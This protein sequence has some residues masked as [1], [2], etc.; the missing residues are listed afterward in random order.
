MPPAPA[1]LDE[2]IEAGWKTLESRSGWKVRYL[3]LGRGTRTWIAFHGFG[4]S[5]LDLVQWAEPLLAGGCRVFLIELP[6]HGK[7]SGPDDDEALT[8]EEWAGLFGQLCR[9]EQIHTLRL[10]GFS[11]GAR[12]A[13]QTAWQ[14]KGTV[15]QLVLCAPDGITNSLWFTLGTRT[16]LG[17]QI[18]A[19]FT[20][21]PKPLFQLT[22]LLHVLGFLNRSLK[23]FVEKEMSN[24]GRRKLAYR[25]W[26]SMRLLPP[27]P[28]DIAKVSNQWQVPVILFFGRHDRIIPIRRGRPLFRRL[29]HCQV[30]L[31]NSGHNALPIMAGK[32]LAAMD[33]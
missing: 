30:H 9:R 1:A 16:S 3:T 29:R 33:V 12:L 18:Y 14:M 19:R 6:W 8:P 13:M 4:Q 27:S 11:L 26:Q 5:P 10:F 28:E 15:E 22:R 2:Q 17:R 23:R 25:S 32:L 24:P 7:S 20:E 31:L 21:N